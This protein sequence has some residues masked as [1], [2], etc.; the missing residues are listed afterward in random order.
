MPEWSDNAIII[1]VKKFAERDCFFFNT[2]SRQIQRIVQG[3]FF[4]TF[5]RNGANRKSGSVELESAAG[6]TSGNGK[7]RIVKRLL[8]SGFV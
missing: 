1:G 4:K 6:R 5:V 8:R 2:K 3:G 7:S